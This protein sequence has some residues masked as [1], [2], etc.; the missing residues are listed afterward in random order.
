MSVTRTNTFRRTHDHFE[1]QDDSDPHAARRVRG[2]LEQIDYT[3]FASNK[4]VIGQVLGPADARQ[5]QKLA[6]AAAHARA[7][8]VAAALK[9]AETG[10]RISPEDLARLAHLRGAFEELTE[11]YEALRRIV[12]RGY[13]PFG[14]GQA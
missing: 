3:A 8:W 12:E 7:V 2:Q 4:E 11:A 1:P 13:V 10:G 14:P 5:F 9:V 6:V